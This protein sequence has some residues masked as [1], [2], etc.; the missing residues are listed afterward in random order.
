MLSLMNL[1]PI[2]V[3]LE[4]FSNVGSIQSPFRVYK[5]YNDSAYRAVDQDTVLK[6]TT[7]KYAMGQT[8]SGNRL[9]Y[10]YYKRV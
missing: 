1:I 4:R 5:F 3:S 10:S 9:T 7:P 8:I 2:R 6:P